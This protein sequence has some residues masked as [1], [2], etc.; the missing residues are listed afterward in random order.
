MR[1]K[2]IVF[3]IVYCLTVFTGCSAQGNEE[4]SPKSTP[5]S[6]PAA[7]TRQDTDEHSE[8]IEFVQTPNIH[9]QSINNEFSLKVGEEYIT[10][11]KWDYEIDI[12]D[13]LGKPLHESEE[14]LGDSA[15]THSGSVIK[16][17]EFEGL[18]L[19]LFTP[20][21][22]RGFWIMQMEVK[23]DKYKTYRGVSVGCNYEEFI[24]I[25]SEADMVIDGRADPTD[26][27]Y[28]FSHNDY[29]IRFEFKD[30]VISEI[31]YYVEIP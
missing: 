1:E 6:T 23:G 21:K 25:Y 30:G 15:D 5:I 7:D 22:D 16:T 8:K 10:L 29:Y 26:C 2:A 9:E 24:D 20:N 14:I 12:I 28:T 13:I 18:V 31:K 19:Y 27:A 11:K 17:Q 3:L 4:T